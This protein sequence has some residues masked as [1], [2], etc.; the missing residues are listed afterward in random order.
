MN[1]PLTSRLQLAIA[2]LDL[3]SSTRLKVAC[4]LL[5]ADRLEISVV[6]WRTAPQAALV[7]HDGSDEGQQAITAARTHGTP[8]LAISRHPGAGDLAHG[9]SVRDIVDAVRRLL[10][11]PRQAPAPDAAALPALPPFLEAIRLDRAGPDYLLLENG[12]LRLVADRPEGRLHLLRRMSLSQVVAAANAAYWRVTPLDAA[13]WQDVHAPEVVEA[14]PLEVVWWRAA[15]QLDP[16]LLQADEGRLGLAAWPD[17]EPASTDPQWLPRARPPAA[18]RLVAGG[19]GRGHRHSARQRGAGRR[20]RA[21]ERTGPAWGEHAG[22]PG[23]ASILRAGTDAFFPA[24]GQALRIEIDGSHAWIDSATSWCSSATWG[25][26]SPP[27]SAR[28]PT[29]NRSAPTCR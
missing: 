6:D 27:P 23:A 25:P 14:W 19:A 21:P 29:P 9:A 1:T 16:S 11:S 8:W 22:G 2:G 12:L 26:A 28:S 7:A 15:R 17:L 4:S 3:V 13:Q 18:A 10:M 20:A 24:R 5:M